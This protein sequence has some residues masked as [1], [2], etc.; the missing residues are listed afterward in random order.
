[1]VLVPPA[2]GAD[3]DVVEASGHQRVEDAAGVGLGHDHGVKRPVA[4]SQGHQVTVHLTCSLAPGHGEEVRSTVVTDPNIG[5]R[6][7]RWREMG[8][9]RHAGNS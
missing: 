3:G 1:M 8:G 4:V 7:W 2:A 9:V 6:R 5:D